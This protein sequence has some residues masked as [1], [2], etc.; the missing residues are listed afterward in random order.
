MARSLRSRPSSEMSVPMADAV[1]SLHS[2]NF[3]MSR[4]GT[5]SALA[6]ARTGTG[7]ANWAMNSTR[8]VEASD[9]AQ[10]SMSSVT[11]ARTAGSNRATA[12]GVNDRATRR[13]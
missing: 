3:F 7:L 11:I 6:T 10:P 9:S 2:L 8:P 4:S 13:R 5:F 1:R 12:A